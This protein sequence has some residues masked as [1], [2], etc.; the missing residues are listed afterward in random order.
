MF[1]LLF[2]LLAIW[3]L[4]SLQKHTY[5]PHPRVL[6][7]GARSL[8][9]RA[10]TDPPCSFFAVFSSRLFGGLRPIAHWRRFKI[11]W[12]AST[13]GGSAGRETNTRFQRL[14]SHICNTGT[15]QFSARCFI[16]SKTSTREDKSSKW[17]HPASPPTIICWCFAAGVDAVMLRSEVKA[18][19]RRT[20]WSWISFKLTSSLRSASLMFRHEA[21]VAPLCSCSDWST[22]VRRQK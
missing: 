10:S 17:L 11:R 13:P 2:L 16:Y 15:Q 5:R 20:V 18:N 21:G 9:I 14:Y 19:K 8:L 1:L 6:Q 4:F 22:P 3:R 12:K 7:C